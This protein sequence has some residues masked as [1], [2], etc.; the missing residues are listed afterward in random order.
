MNFDRMLDFQA[1]DL[2][3]GWM[4]KEMWPE[5]LLLNLTVDLPIDW[6]LGY[7]RQWR[8]LMGLRREEDRE[9]K[10]RLHCEM[11]D[12]KTW[13]VDPYRKA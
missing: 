11:R 4:S 5:L 3:K 1:V 10:Q 8:G 12:R 9:T 13:G 7:K 2:S 6:W